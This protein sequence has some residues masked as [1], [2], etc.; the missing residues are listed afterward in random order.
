MLKRYILIALFLLTG[1]A[2]AQYLSYND[3]ISLIKIADNKAGVKK[4]LINKGLEYFDEGVKNDVIYIT[5]TKT[6]G[7]DQYLV[8]TAYHPAKG[9]KTVSEMSSSASR[10][11]YYKKTANANGFIFIGNSTKPGGGVKSSY[12]NGKYNL[13]LLNE[14]VKGEKLY[15]MV[16]VLSAGK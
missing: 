15:Q 13:S 3:W 16:L 1:S 7:R 2:F 4:Y 12:K 5:Y 9:T 11:D 10:W 8:S 14:T 6:I